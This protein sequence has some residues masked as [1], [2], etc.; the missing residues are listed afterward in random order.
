[1][2]VRI[3][4]SDNGADRLHNELL[5]KLFG[6]SWALFGTPLR[7]V[8]IPYVAFP[9]Q[10]TSTWGARG[11]RDWP[12]LTAAISRGMRKNAQP[13]ADP[14]RSRALSFSPCQSQPDRVRIQRYRRGFKCA[15]RSQ[16]E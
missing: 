1:M 4:L 12:E 13:A 10:A 14:S 6:E 3:T 7:L 15:G 9:L 5:A 11:H 16:Q 8:S 2:D